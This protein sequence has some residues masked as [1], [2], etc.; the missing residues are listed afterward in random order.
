MER[1]KNQ[2]LLRHFKFVAILVI[3]V[4]SDDT[5]CQKRNSR[6]RPVSSKTLDYSKLIQSVAY[7]NI[8][9]NVESNKSWPFNIIRTTNQRKW[10]KPSSSPSLHT[11]SKKK[12]LIK[13]KNARK[14]T[15]DTNLRYTRQRPSR[16]FNIFGGSREPSPQHIIK[17]LGPSSLAFGR[18]KKYRPHNRAIGQSRS[19]S[20]RSQSYSSLPPNS[21]GDNGIR[22]Q[23]SNPDNR[24]K[25][26]F[27]VINDW[28]N[29]IKDST[30]HHSMS[31][32]YTTESRIQPIGVSSLP[33]QNERIDNLPSS[34]GPKSSN[35]RFQPQ[36]PKQKQKRFNNLKGKEHQNAQMI[37][38]ERKPQ[39]V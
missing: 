23:L 1:S 25:R 39:Y 27:D 24:A 11:L 35:K 16:G 37:F 5:L 38:N 20:L 12:G 15:G 22:R 26:K 28:I 6:R 33:L 31:P 36:P 34:K 4:F 18:S 8:N 2:F 30:K 13:P 7:N 14:S 3:V 10:K 32:S 17:K 21:G 9:R 29:R 19:G